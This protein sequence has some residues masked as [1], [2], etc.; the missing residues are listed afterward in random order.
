MQHQGAESC[1]AQGFVMKPDF[2]GLRQHIRQ[3]VG[4]AA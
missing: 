3:A 2:A 4:V 1:G